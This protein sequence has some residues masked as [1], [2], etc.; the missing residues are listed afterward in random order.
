MIII[1]IIQEE[2]AEHAGRVRGAPRG[3]GPA[4]VWMPR[5]VCRPCSKQP[6]APPAPASCCPS[7][8]HLPS[9]PITLLLLTSPYLRWGK[10][11]PSGLHWPQQLPTILGH[12]SAPPSQL[13][14]L[15]APKLLQRGRKEGGN[16]SGGVQEELQWGR[17]H[18]Q[19]WQGVHY[20]SGRAQLGSGAAKPPPDNSSQAGNS[21]KLMQP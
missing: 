16:I 20:P 5:P 2:S 12:K 7:R 3:Q 15:P 18:P 19:G 9:E 21:S 10:K 8:C 17:M 4:G 11:R 1:K 14:S 6:W 13:S